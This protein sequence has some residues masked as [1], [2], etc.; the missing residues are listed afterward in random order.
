V[1]FTYKNRL[2]LGEESDVAVAL[3]TLNDPPLN[4]NSPAS[5]RELWETLEKLARDP[6]V[7][8]L[9]LTGA[10]G[11]TFCAGSDVSGCRET[12]GNPSGRIYTPEA[13][14]L[15][16]LEFIGKPTICAV[17][18]YCMGSGLELAC[19]CDI[20]I[21]SEKAVF[22]RPEISLG[23][24]PAG[25]GRCRLRDVVGPAWALQMMYFG[26]PIDAA[27]AYRIGLAGRIVPAG[28]T[29]AA[30]LD[31]AEVLIDKSPDA[32]RAV[33]K[34]ARRTQLCASEDNCLAGPKYG[35]DTADYADCSS[36]SS[37]TKR[38]DLCCGESGRRPSA[39]L[40]TDNP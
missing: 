3:V 22:S 9:V 16:S 39:S 5:L 6:M 24:S 17:E 27:E 36:S 19:C 30:A 35:G 13:A 28:A 32:L 33:K 26:E 10:G 37:D 8:V 38:S 1:S 18:G 11:R 40:R 25:G 23:L 29:L 12:E 2:V 4:L 31:M 20:R 34:E 15:N 14:A 21:V 7:R